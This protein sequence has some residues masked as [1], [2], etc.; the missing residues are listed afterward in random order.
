MNFLSTPPS[1]TE[2]I[3]STKDLAKPAEVGFFKRT[4]KRWKI[5]FLVVFVCIAILLAVAI[6]DRTSSKQTRP[7]TVTS[8]LTP[9]SPVASTLIQSATP[10][11]VPTLPQSLSAPVIGKKYKIAVILANFPD[12]KEESLSQAEINDLVF[13]GKFSLNNFFQENSYNK[14]GFEGNKSDVYGWLTLSQPV[15]S[16]DD[17]KWGLEA[18][19]QVRDKGVNIDTY[20]Y[21]VVL[22]SDYSASC[23]AWEH[24][25]Y[26][27]KFVTVNVRSVSL[28]R[29]MAHELGHLLGAQHAHLKRCP[30]GIDDD[31][32]C[33][34]ATTQDPYDVMAYMNYLTDFSAANKLILG[35]L[36]EKDQIMVSKSGIYEIKP[37]EYSSGAR[38][39]IIKK[40]DTREVYVL[41]YRKRI[42]FDSDIQQWKQLEGISVQVIGEANGK[43]WGEPVLIDANPDINFLGDVNLQDDQQIEDIKNKLVIKQLS[44]DNTSVK[45]EI[46]FNLP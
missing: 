44:H 28:E 14:V 8:P 27:E 39:V 12:K 21:R 19:Q 17:Y 6:S 33:Q 43:Y 37:L 41:S 40:P 32:S 3:A 11:N 9:I 5:L 30:N 25:Y 24:A 29:E 13:E 20:D 10:L 46:I 23:P 36:D 38:V 1:F 18:L 35:W 2:N 34:I 16:C 26:G 15:T 22:F 4:D 31:T 42:G 45:V 7:V